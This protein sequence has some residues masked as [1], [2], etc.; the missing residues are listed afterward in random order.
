MWPSHRA[1]S[2]GGAATFFVLLGRGVMWSAKKVVN[3]DRCVVLASFVIAPTFVVHDAGLGLDCPD[4]GRHDAAPA[5]CVKGA[6]YPPSK[7]HTFSTDS[8]LSR[9]ERRWRS[10][11]SNQRGAE[12]ADARHS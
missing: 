3:I 5:H 12:T 1:L 2:A 11:A 10:G 9:P 6:P 7:Y 8:S 4:V